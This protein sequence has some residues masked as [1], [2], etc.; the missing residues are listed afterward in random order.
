MWRASDY[1]GSMRWRLGTTGYHNPGWADIFYPEG[2]P[3]SKWLSHYA[4]R[5]DAIEL[6]TTFHAMPT[7]D[8]VRKWAERVSGDFRFA[9]KAPR[10]VTHEVPLAY[11][12]P[13]MEEF[14]A[15]VR[16]LGG[17]LGPVL[18][19]LPPEVSF[20]QVD[21]LAA[22]LDELPNDIR[23]AVEF[24]SATWFRGEAF[25]LLRSKNVAVVAA[26]LEG[27]PESRAVVPTADFLYVRLLGRH[28]RFPDETH[29]RFD[30]TPRLIDWHRRI[31]TAAEASDVTEC[32][33]L[34]NNDY[35][36]H[37]P[38]TLRRFSKIAKVPLAEG[39][40]KQQ[41]LF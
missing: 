40:A 14:L 11:A 6:N 37:A 13:V 26:E 16:A 1:D 30:P 15:A 8:R 4:T 7:E 36:G 31:L 29:E 9:V 12:A 23:F 34:F 5:F 24:R 32:W 38:A 17:R 41:T 33:V 25:E 35:A 2:L 22:L 20:E 19:Q 39:P 18:L 28:G 10:A 21:G 27:H 3:H